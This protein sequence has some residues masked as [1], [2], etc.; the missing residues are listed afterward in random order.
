MRT[1]PRA[2]SFEPRAGRTVHKLVARSSWLAVLIVLV[3]PRA[4]RAQDIHFSQFFNA[5]LALG[6]GN[7][8]VFDGD[9]RVNGLFRQQWRSVTTPYRTFALGGDAANFQGVQ[10]LGVGAWLFNDRA[11]DSHLNQFHLS[12]GA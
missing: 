2:M 12:V 8:G 1:Q 10:G 9:Y 6:P 11:G 5:P 7:I 4:L 3:A